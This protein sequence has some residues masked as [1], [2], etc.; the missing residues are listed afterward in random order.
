MR[1]LERYTLRAYL[2]PLLWCLG[3]F[4]GLYL[5]LDLLGHLDEIVRYRVPWQML[6]SYYGMTVPLVFVQVA[7]FACL[8]AT[9]YTLGNL[10]RSHEVMAMRASGIGPLKIMGPFLWMGLLL[11]GLVLLTNETVA[12]KAAMSTYAIKENY[13]EHP[14]D[15]KAGHR[16][17]KTIQNLAA[18]GQ[19]HTL[20][21]A[22]SFDPVAKKMEGVVILQHGPTLSLRRKIS[23][24]S[25]TWTGE[26]WRF[27]QGAILQ[28]N[29]KGESVGRAVPFDAKI[30]RAGDRPE[31]LEKSEAQAAFMNT[32]DLLR[33]IERFRGAESAMLRKL[34]SDLY[35]KWAAALG[36][37]ILTLVGIPFAIQPVRGG[38]FLGLSMGLGVGLAFYGANALMVALGKGGW[39]PPFAAAWSAPVIFAFFGF[40]GAIK[41]L[42]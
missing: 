6:A 27:E 9:L 42:A 37:F 24:Q 32:Q 26:A 3:I 40:R 23:A 8:M 2:L 31:I 7:P 18:Y 14:A 12:P 17:L 11:S 39:L 19:N 29:A 1:I 15:P 41:R 33:Y 10:N 13:L 20:L 21:Y 4:V 25:A 34:K 30:I 16:I 5:I 22:K 36:P 28:F 38:T 35:A